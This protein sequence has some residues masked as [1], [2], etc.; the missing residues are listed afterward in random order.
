MMILEVG[1][2]VFLPK[3]DPS[4]AVRFHVNADRVPLGPANETLRQWKNT[5]DYDVT[6]RFNG[7][8]LRDEKDLALSTKDDYFVVGDSFSLGWGVEENE[9]YSN[10]LEPLLS[11]RVYN[12]SAP[13]GFDS[14]ERL[15]WYA[16]SK[17]AKTTS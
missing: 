9:R 4:G 1:I 17:G 13:G 11:H 12:V 5:G 15:I 14:Y 7:Y 10:R 16:I 8:G 3:F 6:F 2:W